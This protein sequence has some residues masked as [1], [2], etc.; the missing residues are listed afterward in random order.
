MKREKILK[1]DDLPDVLTP[2]LFADY[3]GI[4]RRRVYEYCQL[5]EKDGGLKSY[6]VG[7]SR[8]IDKVDLIA[9][10]ENLKNRSGIS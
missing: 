7:A 1:L 6:L 4:S 2:Q 10:K 5:S 9:W 8:K 3:I